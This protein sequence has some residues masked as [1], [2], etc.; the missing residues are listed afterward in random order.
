MPALQVGAADYDYLL[1]RSVA[2]QLFRYF[3]DDS[4]EIQNISEPHFKMKPTNNYRLDEYTRFASMRD[5]FTEFIRGARFRSNAGKQ[6]LSVFTKRGD[7][8]E[9]GNTPLVLL[10]GVPVTDHELIYNYDPLTVE[11]INIYYGPCALGS[12]RF[13]GIVELVTYRRLHADLNLNRST[14]VI[15]YEGPQLPYRLNIPD[16]S[17]NENIQNKTPDGR[18]TLLWNPDLK[19]D[20][21]TSIRLPFNTSDLT[22]E[23]QATVEGITN[24]GV[25]IFATVMFQVEE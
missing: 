22:G 12:S 5:I 21:K 3:S 18:H 10:D 23:F 24:D 16:Y 4:N 9:Y 13:D 7:A 11:Q 6:E 17:I 8:Y 19:T 15:S 25:F 20:G 14:Q 2:L 1:D